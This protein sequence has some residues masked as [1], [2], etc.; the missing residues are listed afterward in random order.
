[1]FPFASMMMCSA[2]IYT[3]WTYNPSDSAVTVSPGGRGLSGGVGSARGAVSKA[4][5]AWY[6]EQKCMAV[7]AAATGVGL[8]SALALLSGAIGNDASSIGYWTGGQVTTGGVVTSGFATFGAGDLIGM[9]FN[10]SKVWFSKNG[11]WISGDPNTGFGGFSLG[12]SGPYYPMAN[13]AGGVWVLDTVLA[14]LP[15][16]SFGPL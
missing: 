13:P 14:N 12:F 2:F 1:M 3:N 5:G 4:S 8:G 11:N 6:V 10:D 9:A 7:G 15:P 16:N